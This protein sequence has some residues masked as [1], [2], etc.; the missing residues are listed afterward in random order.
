M[1]RLVVDWLADEPERA[2]GAVPG[3][4]VLADISGFTKL[5]ERLA[6]RGKAGAEEMAELLNG[7]FYELS[8]DV[9]FCP[10]FAVHSAEPATLGHGQDAYLAG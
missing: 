10:P 5:T 8:D 2:Y 3:T 4:C 7:V 6:T 1:P 9:P